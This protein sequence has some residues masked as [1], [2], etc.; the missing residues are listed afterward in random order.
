[1]KDITKFVNDLI[2]FGCGIERHDTDIQTTMSCLANIVLNSEVCQIGKLN[3][4]AIQAHIESI[5]AAH[6][7][8]ADFDIDAVRT[9][10]AQGKSVSIKRIT[11]FHNKL[12][13]HL[14]DGSELSFNATDIVHY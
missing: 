12:S 7:Q 11:E 8:G 3:Y 5:R 4:N 6:Q 1:M 10:L 2:S 13:V 9:R 14:S